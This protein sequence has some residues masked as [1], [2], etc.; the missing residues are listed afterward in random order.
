MSNPDQEI[1][2]LRRAGRTLRQ[3]GSL[4]GI[5]HVAVF[6]RLKAIETSQETV[7]NPGGNTLRWL[8][9]EKKNVLTANNACKSRKPRESGKN[10]GHL[11]TQKSPIPSLSERVNPVG[12]HSDRSTEGKQGVSQQILLEGDDLLAAIKGFLESK[13]IE[14]YRRQSAP[15]CYEVKSDRQTIRIYVD[16]KCMDAPKSP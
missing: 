13:G 4:L 9:K 5:S 15:E 10:V 16:K 14:V 7:T 12:N 1:L 8:P 2:T 6:K 3:I 11:V